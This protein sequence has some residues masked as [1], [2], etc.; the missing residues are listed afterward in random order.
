M[1]FSPYRPFVS[2]S[3][4]NLGQKLVRPPQPAD[5]GYACWQRLAANSCAI[6]VALLAGS[7]L[8]NSIKLSSTDTLDHVV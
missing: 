3:A 5:I 2:K 7:L 1:T 8:L 4:G 6:Q